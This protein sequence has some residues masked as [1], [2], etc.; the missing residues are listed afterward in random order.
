[1][2]QKYVYGVIPSDEEIS[3]GSIGLGKGSREVYTVAHRGLGCVI[4]DY[5]GQEFQNMPK[6]ELIRCLMVHQAVIETVMKRY[7]VLPMK[8]GTLLEGSAQVRGF[9]EQGYTQLSDGLDQVRDKV[10]FEVAA[11]WDTGKV[12]HEIGNQEEVVRLKEAIVGRP[13]EETLEQRIQ[14]GKRVKELLDRRRDGYRQRMVDFLRDTALDVQ[15]N[16]LLSDEMVMNVAFLIQ[17]TR[18]E[19][20]DNR[21]KELDG[22]FHD[23]IDFRIIGPLPP[24]SF[25]TIEVMR[26]SPE[27]L[28]EARH[29]LGLGEAVSEAEVKQ[30]YRSLGVKIHTDRNPGDQQAEERFA[31]VRQASALLLAYCRGREGGRPTKRGRHPLTAQAIEETFFITI[32]RS[33]LGEV[34]GG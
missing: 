7:T 6:E 30:A 22:I 10:E 28:E 29:L 27:K 16:A 11:T 13:A 2:P 8:F 5:Q 25:S 23:E 4:S 12:L 15:P 21:V 20:F 26:L 3:F 1:M 17:K 24:Y 18:Q 34:A 19:D 9:L 31:R 32:K 14:V 33:A